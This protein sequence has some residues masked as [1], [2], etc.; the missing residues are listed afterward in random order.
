MDAALR[1]FA[2]HGYEG[3]SVRDIAAEAQVASGLLY[4]YFPSKQAVLEALFE[5]SAGLV[6]E[7]FARAAAV[8]EPRAR[9][10]ALVGVSARLVR[11]HE[12]FWRVSYGVRFQHAVVAGLAEGIAAQ[13]ALYLR[14]FTS[15]LT[16]IGRPEPELEARLLFAALDGVFQHYV[17]DPA[18]YPLD[19]VIERLVHQHG[20]VP[21]KEP[22]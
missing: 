3:A 18:S 11:E 4:H 19:A 14:L 9:L 20:G 21:A 12:Q 10:G 5:R 17:L 2:R 15:L 1:V 13:S 16:E 22:L 7:A 8:P 6:M